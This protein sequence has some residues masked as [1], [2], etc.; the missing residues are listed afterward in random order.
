MSQTT[1]PETTTTNTALFEYIVINPSTE[2]AFAYLLECLT[3]QNITAENDDSFDET[4]TDAD[5]Q[6]VG[7][8]L[9]IEMLM[10]QIY[11]RATIFCLASAIRRCVTE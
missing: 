8:R 10:P 4:E 7:L 6:A 5:T 3:W 11:F 9:H 1:Q 2:H